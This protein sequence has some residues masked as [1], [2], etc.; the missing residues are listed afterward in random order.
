MNK[1]KIKTPAKVNL[2]LKLIGERSDGFTD[3]WSIVQTVSLFDEIEI[4]KTDSGLGLSSND[5]TIPLDESNTVAKSWA[6]MCQVV[7]MELGAKIHLGKKIPPQSGLGGGSSDAAAVLA[8]ID[9]LYGLGIDIAMLKK[10]G[11]AVGSDVP[12]FFGSGTS[13]ITGRGEIVQDIELDKDFTLLLIKPRYGMST[14]RAYNIAKKGLT[15][16]W[17]GN[18]ITPLQ[19]PMSAIEACRIGNDLQ[20]AFFNEYPAAKSIIDKLLSRGAEHAALTGSGS[21]IF[22][23]FPDSKTAMTA[24]EGFRDIWREVVSPVNIS[25]I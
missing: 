15:K 5:P 17:A 20:R 18:N 24:S 6:A 14:A 16:G 22:G 11:A 3:I 13:L 9:S 25:L 10:I 2:C 23:L 4:E 7:G 12:L 8:G 1:L 21:A 19:P